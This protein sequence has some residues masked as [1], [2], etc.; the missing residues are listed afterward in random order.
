M[1][2]Y[3]K[4]LNNSFIFAVGNLGSKIVS[5]FL[6]PLYTYYLSS[7]EYGTVDLTITTVNMLLPV[8]S[9]SVFEAILR[10]IMDKDHDSEKTLSNSLA[11][12]LAGFFVISLSYPILRYFN[13]LGTDLI[14]FYMIL[15]VQIIGSIF[16]NYARAIGKVKIFAVNGILLTFSTG[17]LNILFLAYYNLGIVGYYWA[18]I[19]AYGIS[20]MY[21]VIST[22][23]YKDI[24]F[25][26]I[27]ASIVKKILVF[28]VPMVPSTIMWWL[29]NA[30]SRYFIR[31]FVGVSANGLFA[32]ASRIPSLLNIVNQVFNQAWQLSAV[33]EYNKN[34]KNDF[35]SN[36]FNTLS[37]LML[38]ASS[39]ILIILK[40]L[41][42]FLFSAEYFES[43]RIVPFLLLG[44]VFSSFS[45][46]FGTTYFV[47]KQTKA[48][49]KT[50]VYGGVL[51]FIL[52]AA[53]IPTLGTIGAG[54][55]S[56]FS[57][58]L[59]FLIRYFDT[60]KYIEIK[61]NWFSL[62]ANMIIISVQTGILFTDLDILVELII[63]GILLIFLVFANRNLLKLGQK[64]LVKITKKKSYGR[65]S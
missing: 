52:N 61:I 25:S 1:N 57:F 8:V 50:S 42:E 54:I 19:L 14:F 34:N 49:F 43:W 3:K 58:L 55:S 60:K 38:I 26:H 23:A 9:V 47:A 21:L 4:L 16:A 32:V 64:I 11:I 35:Y 29:I 30:S 37:S 13:V 45:A 53:F 59:M 12:S 24:R 65:D 63:Q 20:A 15:F 36:V 41:F 6:V 46:F 7:S 51:S 31:A 44:A 22:K 10:F 56:M 40:P 33:E 48:M 39:F 5:F 17:V 2:S 27:D 18:L 28:S 62:L